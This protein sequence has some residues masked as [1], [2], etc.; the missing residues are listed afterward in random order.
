MG[1]NGAA[2]DKVLRKLACQCYQRNG[3][4]RY[5]HISAVPRRK[6]GKKRWH[7]EP[8]E[9]QVIIGREIVW[10]ILAWKQNASDRRCQRQYCDPSCEAH[11]NFEQFSGHE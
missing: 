4:R 10:K 5:R 8:S 1:G 2:W 9:M 7:P 6:G 3:D 11:R